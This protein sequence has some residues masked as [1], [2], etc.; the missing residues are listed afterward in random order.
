MPL[1]KQQQEYADS[2]PSDY[3]SFMAEH[4]PEGLAHLIAECQG[5]MEII[6]A[7]YQAKETWEQFDSRQ[8]AAWKADGHQ[9]GYEEEYGCSRSTWENLISSFIER[10]RCAPKHIYPDIPLRA[11]ISLEIRGLD[12]EEA[13]DV[14]R[15]YLG[16]PQ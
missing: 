15:G 5:A 13:L 9:G 11:Y 1:G 14:V 10:D 4:H 16:V 8:R 2:L 3:L 12:R 7:S 6:E